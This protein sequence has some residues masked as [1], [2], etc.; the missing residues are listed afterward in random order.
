M[1][2]A[3]EKLKGRPLGERHLEEYS[4]ERIPRIPAISREF[5]RSRPRENSLCV[6]ATDPFP[7][8]KEMPN[9]FIR[10]SRRRRQSDISR[11]KDWLAP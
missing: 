6:H 10:A 2:L 7:A 3:R 8:A 11:N 1:A 4:S 5:F 9:A